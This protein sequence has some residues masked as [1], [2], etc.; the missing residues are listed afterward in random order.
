MTKLVCNTIVL[1]RRFI[2]VGAS[3]H[4]A[5]EL[6]IDILN[7]LMAWLNADALTDERRL[8]ETGDLDFLFV[9]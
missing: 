2:I 8:V 4:M 7:A 3:V 6:F 9:L 1:Q 5:H